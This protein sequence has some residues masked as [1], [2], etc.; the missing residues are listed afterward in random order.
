MRLEID[1][2]TNLFSD[3]DLIDELSKTGECLNNIE[4]SSLAISTDQFRIN[5]YFDVDELFKTGKKY[6]LHLIIRDY[7]E[8]LDTPYHI[9]LLKTLLNPIINYFVDIEVE[10]EFQRIKLK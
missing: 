1:D 5:I 9:D 3:K 6:A 4:S 8:E 7:Q 2:L 10:Q